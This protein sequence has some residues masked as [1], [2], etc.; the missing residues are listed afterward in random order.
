ML[1]PKEEKQLRELTEKA[2]EIPSPLTHAD[3]EEMVARVDCVYD[4]CPGMFRDIAI[5]GW[6]HF[7]KRLTELADDNAR[8]IQEVK[9]LSQKEL[10]SPPEQEKPHD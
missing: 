7:S 3:L 1:N 10:D 6:N 5:A 8:L 4:E 9:R 2:K